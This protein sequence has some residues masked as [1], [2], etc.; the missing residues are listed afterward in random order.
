[1][2]IS[3]KSPRLLN[4]YHKEK[5]AK[6]SGLDVKFE[7][8]M[9]NIKFTAIKLSLTFMDGINIDYMLFKKNH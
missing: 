9:Q 5:Y 8:K 7:I 1:M 3:T 4:Q 6:I 2:T